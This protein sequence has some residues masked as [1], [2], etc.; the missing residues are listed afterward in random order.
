MSGLR[1][2]DRRSVMAIGLFIFT[3]VPFLIACTRA[4]V[5]TRLSGGCIDE[6]AF[7]Y[8]LYTIHADPVAAMKPRFDDD[9][10]PDGL[11]QLN[12]YLEC[13]ELWRRNRIGA[14]LPG[15]IAVVFST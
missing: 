13:P 6:R 12:F 3:A 15:G 9:V 5:L 2:T 11:S 7:M 8:G 4:V 1:P 14:L 10:R